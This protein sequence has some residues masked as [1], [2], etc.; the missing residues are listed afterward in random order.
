MTDEPIFVGSY[1]DLSG[2]GLSGIEKD[3]VAA[4]LNATDGHE[5]VLVVAPFIAADDEKALVT[6]PRAPRVAFGEVLRETEKAI[7]FRSGL[8]DETG[9]AW[10]PKSQA[11]LFVSATGRIRTRQQGL[12]DFESPRGER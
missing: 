10:V 4:G 6:S 7:H 1:E 11:T 5:S 8:G 9:R 12:G 2:Y 3:A